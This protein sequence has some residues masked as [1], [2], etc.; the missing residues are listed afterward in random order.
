MTSRLIT[1]LGTDTDP[2]G[3]V[4]P[5]P[6]VQILWED[7][8]GDAAWSDVGDVLDYRDERSWRVIDFGVLLEHK[9]GKGGYYLMAGSV[10]PGSRILRSR[11]GHTR[12]IPSQWAKVTTVGWLYEDGRFR[13]GRG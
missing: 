9:P 11:L 7:A 1:R 13:R 6:V 12:K 8:T 3:L 10:V 2:D 4:W 5:L